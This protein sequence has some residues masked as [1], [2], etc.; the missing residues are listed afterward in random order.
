VD[1]VAWEQLWGDKELRCYIRL[2]SRRHF[3]GREGRED[4]EQEA[5]CW[6]CKVNPGLSFD[7]LCSIA[8][9]AIHSRL[10][11]EVRQKGYPPVKV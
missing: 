9:H 5:Y 4:A 11:A 3:E 10:R 8:E 2:E 1:G 6:L 7:E